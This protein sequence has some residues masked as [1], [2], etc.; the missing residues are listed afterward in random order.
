MHGNI[1]GKITAWILE[2]VLNENFMID[3]EIVEDL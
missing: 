1:T 3:D 2:D